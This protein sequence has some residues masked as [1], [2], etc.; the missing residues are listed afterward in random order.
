MVVEGEALLRLRHLHQSLHLD[1]IVQEMVLAVGADGFTDPHRPVVD[2]RPV[3][4]VELVESM[5]IL[6]VRELTS[7]TL[8][9]EVVAV[10]LAV[11]DY[12]E[13]ATTV[14]V[15]MDL[16]HIRL[17]HPLMA[18]HNLMEDILQEVVMA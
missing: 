17:F 10:E 2:N 5:V 8:M 18:I 9:S 14:R 15:A 16:A 7:R 6:E 12:P 11:L 13:L 3:D 4:K 1:M